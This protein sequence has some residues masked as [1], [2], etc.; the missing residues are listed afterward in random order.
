[1]PPDHDQAYPKE[2]ESLQDWTAV[3]QNTIVK[4]AEYDLTGVKSAILHIQASLDTTTAHTGTKFITQ[5]SG[6]ESGDEDWQDY[7]EFVALIG[8]AATDLI[9]DDPL[10]AGSTVIALTGHTSFVVLGRWRYIKDA[11]LANSELVRQSETDTDDINI[12]DGTT[13]AHVVT[14]PMWNTAMV[15]NVSIS[16]AAKRLRLIVDNS[17][18]ADGSTLVY[19]AAISTIAGQ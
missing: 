12:L 19:K 3:A 18:D 8:E 7:N 9:E 11:T 15:Q 2:A 16:K 1:M 14:T 5:I 13:N 17:Y 6:A 10:A 4:S